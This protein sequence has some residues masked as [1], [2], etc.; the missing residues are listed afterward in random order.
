M[1]IYTS[2]NYYYTASSFTTLL[3]H[4]WAGQ[5]ASTTHVGNSKYD[6]KAAVIIQIWNMFYLVQRAFHF[7]EDNFLN[8][9]FEVHQFFLMMS[10]RKLTCFFPKSSFMNVM[11][12]ASVPVSSLLGVSA[13]QEPLLSFRDTVLPSRSRS[14]LLPHPVPTTYH[15][16]CQS[17]KSAC[18]EETLYIEL[19]WFIFNLQQWT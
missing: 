8:A 1:Y 5:L 16:T 4:S 17:L 12:A 15:S 3:L 18:T 9:A 13:C 11:C 2:H 14:S 10:Y 19:L 6:L 7:V